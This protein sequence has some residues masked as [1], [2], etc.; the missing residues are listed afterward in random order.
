MRKP[1]PRKKTT[2]GKKPTIVFER[3][4]GFPH[5]RVVG[6]DEVGRGCLAGPVVAAAA[7]LPDDWDMPLGKLAKRLPEVALITDSKKMNEKNRDALAPWIRAHV[8]AF[9]I[10]HASVS[11]I[12]RLNI[13]HASH[14]AMH[15]ATEELGAFDHVLVD[16][17]AVPKYYRG[18]G[19]AIIEGDLKCLS[20]ACAS[21]LAKVYRDQWMRE[22]AVLHPGFGFEVHKGYG[23]PQHQMALKTLGVSEIHRRSFAPVRLALGLVLPVGTAIEL[24]GE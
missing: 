11:E 3:G 21:I 20:I 18:R 23:T 7:L 13:Y 10:G 1:A 6:V 2:A 17:N 12:D 8:K 4:A 16:G 15:R 5:F 19:T 22:L 9:G 14:L 24:S